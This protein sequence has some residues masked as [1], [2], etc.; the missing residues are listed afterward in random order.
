MI[1]ITYCGHI[2][3]EDRYVNASQIHAQTWVHKA[4]YAW[5]IVF[6]NTQFCHSLIRK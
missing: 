2:P 1:T 6:V 3:T 5:F 4:P